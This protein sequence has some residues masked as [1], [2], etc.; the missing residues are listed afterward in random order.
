MKLSKQLLSLLAFCGV[1]QASATVRTVNAGITGY[2]APGMYS[3]ISAAIT[4]ASPGDTLMIAGSTPYDAAGFTVSKQLVFIGAGYNPQNVDRLT[5]I[6]SGV[7][8]LNASSNGSVF[9]GMTFN[10]AFT[11]SANI[12]NIT[13]RRCYLNGFSTSSTVTGFSMI[14]CVSYGQITMN[15]TIT[16]SVFRN[17]VFIGDIGSGAYKISMASSNATDTVDHN[18][19]INGRNGSVTGSTYASGS[20]F[21][22]SVNA[23]ITNNI[24]YNLPVF[25]TTILSS[26]TGNY[27]YNNI[28][29]RS[30]TTL[31]T[32]PQTGNFGTGN[33]NNTDPLFTTIFSS[34][35]N[36]YL[37]LNADNIRPASGSPCLFA[38]TDGTAIGATGGRFPVYLSTNNVLTGEPPIPS[39]RAFNITSS[40]VVAPGTP[41]NVT[42][43]AKKIN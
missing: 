18:T 12:S 43:R 13:F 35:T 15:T 33:I 1:F 10:S 5:T 7:V 39:V 37:D 34:A 6:V 17:N 23:I 19:F 40:T 30:G 21:M 38:G 8:T 28:C 29:Y 26:C 41:I 16:N 4:A 36:I 2:P 20:G 24:F 14:E 11:A 32:I 3:S 31:P 42:V 27:F 25:S 9:M 22:R